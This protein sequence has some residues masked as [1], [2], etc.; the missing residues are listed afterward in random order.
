MVQG[1]YEL[2]VAVQVSE[3]WD[4]WGKRGSVAFDWKD[5]NLLK[6]YLPDGL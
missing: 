3:G 4:V 6:Q 2:L 1:F 5:D